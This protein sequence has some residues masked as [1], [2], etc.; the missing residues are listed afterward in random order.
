[1]TPFSSW[2][3]YYVIV[4]SSAGALIGLQFIAI[5]LMADIPVRDGAAQAGSAFAT[6]TIVHFSVVLFLAG[7]MSAPWTSIAPVLVQWGIVGV[8]GL[9]YTAIV[10][11]RMRGQG[12]YRPE[13]EDWLFHAILP[14]LVYATIAAAAYAAR[15]FQKL[16]LFAV[17]GAVMLMLFI[18]IHNTWDAVMY[19]VFVMR[20]R[21]HEKK[22]SPQ[23]E[24]DQSGAS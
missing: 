16:S 9:I 24:P 8:A 5:S 20:R 4:G 13:F 19:H 3:N 6:P 23:P 17:A 18:G 11:K 14:S 22:R 21:L 7:L 12:A 2:A 10:A 15:D 1:M